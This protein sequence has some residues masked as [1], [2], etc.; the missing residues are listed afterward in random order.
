MGQ[1]DAQRLVAGNGACK[2]RGHHGGRIFCRFPGKG[3][4]L[5]PDAVKKPGLPEYAAVAGGEA[6]DAEDPEHGD[7]ASAVHQFCHRRIGG[8][9]SEIS[10]VQNLIEC[11]VLQKQGR[12]NGGQDGGDH[13]FLHRYPHNRK[14]HDHRRRKEGCGMKGELGRK[15]F[16]EVKLRRMGRSV[17]SQQE[18][19]QAGHREGKNTGA[20]HIADVVEYIRLRE[21]RHQQGAGGN[22]GT[23][24][25][26]VGAGHHRAAEK[27]HVRT[28]GLSHGGADDAHGGGGAEGGP[29]QHRKQAV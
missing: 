11:P 8:C 25:A 14:N 26:E 24:V 1:N 21:F 13:R 22:R 6:D 4:Y 19:Q 2:N 17:S 28:H 23:A 20:H 15:H 5:V 3:L 10:A 7:D 12:R 9:K 16:P 27:P 18:V 29:G